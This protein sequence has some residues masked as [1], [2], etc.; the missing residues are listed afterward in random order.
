MSSTLS[1]RQEH[2]SIQAGMVQE[3]LRVRHL[4]LK[5]ARSRLASRQ[6]GLKAHVHG[7]TPTPARPHLLIVPLPGP[8]IYNPSHHEISFS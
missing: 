8:S 1:S 4:Y 6:L 3:E 2:G 5:A 7:D